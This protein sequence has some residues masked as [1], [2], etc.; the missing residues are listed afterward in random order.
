M[1][2]YIIAIAKS[3]LA[4]EVGQQSGGLL[5]IEGI[6]RKHSPSL[7][8]LLE[9]SRDNSSGFDN[10]ESNIDHLCVIT[11]SCQLVRF[12][13]PES[14]ARL[15][16]R[17]AGSV[18]DLTTHLG[19]VAA[20][21]AQSVGRV[22]EAIAE[23][24]TWTHKAAQFYPATLFERA[25]SPGQP[26]WLPPVDS[27]DVWAAGV[28]YE[29]SRAARQEEAVDGGDVYARVYAAER[30]E[31]FFKAK[32]NWAVGPCAEIG[33]RRDANWSVP[34]PEVGLVINPGLEIVGVLVGNDVSSRDIEGANPLYLPQ[35]KIYTA[36]CALGPGIQL[37]KVTDGWPSM[38]IRLWVERDGAAIIQDETHT[39]RLRRRPDELVAYLGRCLSFPEGAVLLT[40]TGVV[41]PSEFTLQ[42]GDIVRIKIE[43]VGVLE[44][45]VKVV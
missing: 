32:G 19:S 41:P 31:L 23:L 18:V 7:Q 10:R 22:D 27:Q 5:D 35:A 1:I 4:K 6:R 15:G 33:I 20:W 8:R 28:T 13:L 30:P 40:G 26:H 16:V 11:S 24:E 39:R 14:G 45:T 21:L 38:S 3:N 34:E 44:N 29:R 37:G 25:P 43:G 12:F 36:S 9:T 2:A 42:A 17:T